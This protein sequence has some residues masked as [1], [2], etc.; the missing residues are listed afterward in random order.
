MPSNKPSL[1]AF[2]AVKYWPI[3]FGLACLRLIITL[4]W[5]WRMAVG[6][7]IGWLLY[8][9]SGH[10]RSIVKT[11][12]SLC[13]S[14]LTASEQR[15]MVRQIFADNGIGIIETAMAWWSSRDDFRHR[16]AIE[17]GQLIEQAQIQGRGV[18]LVG[19]HYTSLDLGGI[20]LAPS[21]PYYATYQRHGNA[22]MDRIIRRG[23]L[24]HLP[25]IVEREDIRQ[26]IRLLK[27]GK[28]VWLA[29]DQDVGPDRSVFAPFFGIE[30]ATTPI[31][32]R[33]A[34]A[35][36]AKV[37]Q[38]SHHRTH[39][40]QRYLLTVSDDLAKIPSG[41][42]VADAANL[43]AAIEAKVRLKPSQYLWLHRRFKTRPKDSPHIY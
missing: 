35:T 15:Y 24:N 17:G 41:D 29:P 32:S 22:L 14:H 11:N 36:G 23:R 5:A 34:T 6:R 33:L 43:N 9:L 4:P 39:Q 8:Q 21:Y 12:I 16:V 42:L 31:V 10:R 1:T 40:D 13:F 19:A 3:W 27:Q 2:Y 7:A 30:T 26:V 28:V 20:L 38:F 18:L 37:L 25:G